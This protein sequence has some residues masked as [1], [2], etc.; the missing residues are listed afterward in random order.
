MSFRPPHPHPTFKNPEQV[1]FSQICAH[2][3]AQ[4]CNNGAQGAQSRPNRQKSPWNPCPFMNIHT[5]V[6][7]RVS[8]FVFGV[9]SELF[10]C[11]LRASKI[12]CLF[13]S[14]R[15]DVFAFFHKW[16]FRRGETHYFDFSFFLQFRVGACRRFCV[17]FSCGK[18]ISVRASSDSS[19]SERVSIDI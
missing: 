17:F 18:Q 6:S 1:T 8:N 2:K 9:S 10:F 4:G 12:S 13:V 16:S 19:V 7:Q 15:V 11:N 5:S 14:L 3:W